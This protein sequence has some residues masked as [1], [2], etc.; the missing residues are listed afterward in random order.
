MGRAHGETFRAEIHAL[1]AL[2]T[3]LVVTQGKKLADTRQVLDV[4][5]AHLPILASFDAALS[6]ELLGIAEGADLEPA[7]IVVLN[8]YTDLKDLGPDVLEGQG[9]SLELPSDLRAR[10][11]RTRMSFD[12]MTRAI[13]GAQKPTASEDED[14]S[15]I[16]ARTPRGAVLGQTWDMHGSAAPYVCMLHVPPFE[17]RPEAWMLSLTGCLGMAGMSAAGVGVTINNLRSHDAR[18]GIVWTALVRRMLAE[19]DARTALDVLMKAP[20]S[21]GH[22][23]LVAD[24][25]HAFGVETSGVLKSV[26]FESAAF[27][28]AALGND[29]PRAYVHTNHCVGETV[30]A[31]SSIAPGSTTLERYGWLTKDVEARPLEDAMDLFARLGSHDGYPRSVCTHLASEETP[32]AMATCAGIVMD[33]SARRAWAAPGCIHGVSPEELKFTSQALHD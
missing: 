18:L 15:A 12:E 27:D 2:R 31:V 33:L 1:A 25:T 14:C 28:S 20:M 22:H 29:E 26:V 4:A 10:S 32:H 16:A 24:A 5:R 7:A 21:S 3:E 23:Y 19:R 17:D 11:R 6:D 8:H 30:A 13:E 9:V